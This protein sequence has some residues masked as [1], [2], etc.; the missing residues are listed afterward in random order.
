MPYVVIAVISLIL[1][2]CSFAFRQTE[3]QEEPKLLAKVERS[4]CYGSCPIY[5]LTIYFDGTAIYR[6]EQDTDVTG[7]KVF[8][9]TKEQ[10]SQIRAEFTRKGFLVINGKC[11]ECIDVTDSP[12][13]VITYQG[14]GPFKEISYYHGC[15]NRWSRHLGELEKRI[16]EITGVHEWIGVD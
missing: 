11:C 4:G 8:S 9:L 12:S 14:N 13:T 1:S 10:L 6:G 2:S 15:L 7:G 16:L 3:N 5:S